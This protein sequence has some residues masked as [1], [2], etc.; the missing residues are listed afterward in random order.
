MA[1]A[2]GKL[3]QQTAPWLGLGAVVVVA[4]VLWSGLGSN[5]STPDLA[6]TR[7][8]TAP[9]V[10]ENIT[11]SVTASGVVKPLTPVNISPKQS[12]R[13]AT[14]YVEQGDRVKAGQ[15][16]AR[17][18]A[19]DLEGPLLD[20]QGRVAAA[21]ANLAKL[22]AGN[23]PQE[24]AQ[25]EA[26]QRDAAAQLAT[27]EQSFNRNQALVKVG[28]ISQSALDL[29]NDQYRSAQARLS[30]AQAQLDLLKAGSRQEDIA[31]ARAQVLQ[32]RGNLRTIQ[33]QLDNTVIRAP[34]AGIITQK[35]TNPG[36]F[37]TPTTSASATSSATSS[38]ILSLANS[39][40]A[41]ISVAESD[42][43]NIYPGQVVN[44]QVDAYPDQ[45]FK[46]K[47]RLVAPEAVVVQNV[48]SF[49]VRVQV[50]AAA[51]LPPL[52]SG[53]NLKGEFLVG[54]VKDALMVPTTSVVMEQETTG[55]YLPPKSKDEAKEAKPDFQPI[56]VGATVGSQTQVLSG[57]KEGERVFVTL[58]A[59]RKPNDRP[60]NTNSP[61]GSPQPNSRTPR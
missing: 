5:A 30:A 56:K 26:S 21:Q 15:V 60:V 17:M 41:V 7:N 19:T 24:V 51:G 8:Q 23:R 25:A 11:I 34:F 12:G 16:L 57:L 44:L 46:G 36:A 48:T 35:F 14:L 39:L 40:E 53:M 61:L 45:V 22:Q 1:A 43:R 3:L 6:Q 13:L 58:P 50:L 55:V 29:S 31:A 27:A 10:R 9:V 38:S 4:V 33:T 20:A 28:A 47:V 2:A 59:R 52:R 37:V 54:Q 42:I 32:A 18:D 49:E